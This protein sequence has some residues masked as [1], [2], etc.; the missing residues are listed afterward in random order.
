[1]RLQRIVGPQSL[2]RARHVEA[3]PARIVEGVHRAQQPGIG[4]ALGRSDDDEQERDE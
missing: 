2:G 4:V 3:V 1:V